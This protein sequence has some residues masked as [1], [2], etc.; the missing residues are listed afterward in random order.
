MNNTEITLR[1]DLDARQVVAQV[2]RMVEGF[3]HLRLEVGQGVKTVQTSMGH[4]EAAVR[5][6]GGGLDDASRSTQRLEGG[7]RALEGST[8]RLAAHVAAATGALQ[9]TRG[10]M[11]QVLQTTMDLAKAERTLE[12]A[13]GDGAAALA[14][15]RRTCAEL[16]LELMSTTQA[17]AKFA[18]ATRG[19]NLEGYQTQYIFKAVASAATVM[20]LSADET[21]GALLALTQMVSKGSVQAEELR[22]QLGERLPGAFQI[23]A[24]GMG[25][26]T[27]QLSKMLEQ[28]QVIASDFLPKF[29]RELKATLGDQTA[30]AS[31]GPTAQLNRLKNAFTELLAAVG[32]SG[33]IQQAS[34]DMGELADTMKSA[35]E[36]GVP[37]ELGGYLANAIGMTKS[38][39]SVL[40]TCR[41]EVLGL[42]AAYGVFLG[43]KVVGGLLE[44][45][46]A[47][48][49]LIASAMANREEVIKNALAEAGYTLQVGRSTMAQIQE[50]QASLVGRSMAIQKAVAMGMLTEAEAV[51]E[52]QILATA[53]AA[54][55]QAG[56][57]AASGRAAG[58]FAAASSILGGPIGWI[59]LLLTVGIG[60]WV[61]WGG[62]SKSAA[63][64]A[65]EAAEKA[66]RSRQKYE[67]LTGDLKELNQVLGD[68]KAKA[69]DKARAQEQ[70][71]TVVKQMLLVY[72]DLNAFIKKEGENYALTLDDLKKFTE[73][74][75][76]DTEASV[77]N[78]EAKIRE[79]QALL[80]NAVAQG[81]MMKAGATG[82][83]G[84]LAVLWDRQKIKG[85]SEELTKLQEVL[86]KLLAEQ[87]KWQEQDA[88]L[89]APGGG[90]K[91]DKP[92]EESTTA[93]ERLKSDLEKRKFLFEKEAYDRGQLREFSKAEEAAWLEKN[94]ANYKLNA[95]ERLQAEKMLFEAKRAVMAQTADADVASLRRQMEE[96]KGQAQERIRL[97]EK[98]AKQIQQ[99]YG[100]DSKE[101]QAAA[102]EVVRIQREADQEKLRM[103]EVLLD[104]QTANQL[105]AL[106]VEEQALNRQQELGQVK[107]QAYLAALSALENQKYQVQKAALEKRLELMALDPAVDASK[108]EQIG[109]QLDALKAKHQSRQSELGFQSS[110]EGRK[111]ESAAGFQQALTDYKMQ[112]ADSFGTWHE[113]GRTALG[114]LEGSFAD[115]FTSLTQKGGTFGEKMRNLW[116]SFSQVGV[117]ALMKIAAQELVLWGIQKAKLAWEAIKT[118]FTVKSTAVDV[119]SSAAKTTAATTETV[120]NTGAAVSGFTKA[121]AGIPFVGWALA[122]GFILAFLGMMGSLKARAVGGLVTRPEVT[123]LGEA[124]PELVAPESDFKD[125]AQGLVLMGGNLQANLQANQDRVQDLHMQAASYAQEA[126]R[127][128]ERNQAQG[129]SFAGGAGDHYH[130]HGNVFTRDSREM[131]EFFNEGRKAWESANG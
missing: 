54:L 90:G 69:E 46:N 122:L 41:S 82:A 121:H 33:A 63:D 74:K 128:G 59:T 81:A 112:A 91:K 86:K 84:G 53:G 21:S 88:R 95:K 61:A 118:A 116:A 80:G 108:L 13:T 62:A 29:A 87:Q 129:R 92:T 77:R 40:W 32:R 6:L 115:F 38:L 36:N 97:A 45:V 20:G 123:L 44:W 2:S 16:G 23:A 100:A 68:S 98:A 12:Y 93:L 110:D 14:W 9:T 5:K 106:A 76:L 102:T 7:T 130:L 119:A 11:E 24:R 35:S 26:T 101:A 30:T 39:A 57:M 65:M 31:L 114:G 66:E 125:W 107:G 49:V 56:A 120:A 18:A 79:A 103:Q 22:G 71:N 51:A 67:A 10:F 55:E 78:T 27:Q 111:N 3:E 1:F 48:R 75:K 117:Q 89:N 70:L 28:G 113:F 127:Q 47:K 50:A 99:R 4:S 34:R 43:M 42:A 72:P 124:G 126:Q 96:A 105:A 17:Y 73:Q 19:T 94:L 104:R 25:V 60:A 83:Q 8:M 58:G 109:A 52:R 37:R 131:G 64:E 15:V 85:A